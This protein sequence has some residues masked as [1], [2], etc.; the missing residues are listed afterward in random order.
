MA[1]SSDDL[2]WGAVGRAARLC[3][4]CCGSYCRCAPYC[5]VW[6]FPEHDLVVRVGIPALAPVGRAPPLRA[7]AGGL[8]AV[9]AAMAFSGGTNVAAADHYC[10]TV[11]SPVAVALELVKPPQKRD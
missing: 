1:T 6:D 7:N 2:S 3:W 9:A 11:F 8:A 10:V 5:C 4:C